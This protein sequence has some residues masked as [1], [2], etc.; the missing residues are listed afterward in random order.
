M[1]NLMPTRLD[2]YGQAPQ[3]TNVSFDDRNLLRPLQIS[4]THQKLMVFSSLETL[5]VTLPYVCYVFGS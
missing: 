5:R 4:N 3:G 2:R 1:Y